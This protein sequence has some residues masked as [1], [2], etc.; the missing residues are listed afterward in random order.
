M[1]TIPLHIQRRFE[2]RW[3]SRFA[4]PV[5]SNGPKVKRT[6]E[7]WNE[8]LTINERSQHAANTKQ[9]PAGLRRWVWSM[10]S[11]SMSDEIGD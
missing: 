9:R 6:K 1:S 11:H 2:Q 8:S 5:A 10:L 7:D 4:P 3:A